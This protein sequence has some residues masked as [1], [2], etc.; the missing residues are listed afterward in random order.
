MTESTAA[1]RQ[2]AV[3]E[4][5]QRMNRLRLL[6][7]LTTAELVQ[8]ALTREEAHAIVERLR[9]AA[10]AMFPGKEAEF[11]LLYRPRFERI[12]RSRFGRRRRDEI[13]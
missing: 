9:R 4:E 8:S 7:N 12:I 6:V 3:A 11:E 1:S 2:R 5:N 10:L 13:Q